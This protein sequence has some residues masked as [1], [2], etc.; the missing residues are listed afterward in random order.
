V[1]LADLAGTRGNEWQRLTAGA[2]V[3]MVVPL[4]VFISLQRYFVR[5]LLVGGLKG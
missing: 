3:S 2:F 1:K 5:G 4:I